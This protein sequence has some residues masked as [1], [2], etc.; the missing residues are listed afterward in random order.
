MSMSLRFEPFRQEWKDKEAEPHH[1]STLIPIVRHGDG[2]V[3]LGGQASRTGS[4]VIHQVL[5]RKLKLR[6]E[7]GSAAEWVVES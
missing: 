3:A 5:K 6:V 1:S 7:E 2:A 4:S